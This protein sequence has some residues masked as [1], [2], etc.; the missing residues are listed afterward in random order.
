MAPLE[1][2]HAFLTKLLF[3]ELIKSSHW[4]QFMKR[5]CQLTIIV[6]LFAHCGMVV[7]ADSS[8]Q[9]TQQIHWLTGLDEALARAKS[10]NKPVFLDFFN[11][12]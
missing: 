8:K 1:M 4:S 12:K 7:A 5:L 11:P 6:V 3:G 10:E 9:A 2:I